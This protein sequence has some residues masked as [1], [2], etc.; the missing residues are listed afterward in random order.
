MK[1]DL[2]FGVL[3]ILFLLYTPLAIYLS[4]V[5]PDENGVRDTPWYCFT[6]SFWAPRSHKRS[7]IHTAV[8]GDA[9]APRVEDDDVAAEAAKMR[10]R[11]AGVAL[12]PKARCVEAG[13]SR[14]AAPHACD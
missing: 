7:A 1:L 13:W 14:A 2:V 6:P 8:R 3:T 12:S 11:L 9:P 4:A 5:L 10:V